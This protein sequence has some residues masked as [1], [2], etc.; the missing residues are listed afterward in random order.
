V[1]AGARRALVVGVGLGLVLRVAALWAAPR[2]GYLPD[3][4]D[5]M[6]WSSW[7]ATHGATTIY[8]MEPEVVPLH[9]V[10]IDPNTNLPANYL[11]FAPHAFNYPPFSAW[12]F[13]V[14]GVLWHALD[15]DARTIPVP[16]AL[17]VA[18]ERHGL[19][20]TVRFPRVNTYLTRTIDALPSFVFDVLLGLGVVQLVRALRGVGGTP[21]FALVF[22]SPVV[23]LDGAL[24]GQ[25]D[26]WI[27]SMLVWCLV[28]WLRGRWI[29][30]GAMYGLAVVTKPQAILFAPVLAFGLLAL[31]YRRGGS[32]KEVV[33]GLRAI[34]A[35]ALVVVAVAA[36]FMAHDAKG[37][38]GAWRWFE[39]SYLG[40]IGSDEYAYTTLNAFNLW[41]L[42]LIAA[43]PSDETWWRLL[44]SRA[45]SL[46]GLSK[47]ATG[48]VLLVVAIAAAALACARRLRW[49]DMACV[50]FA[51]VVLL[52]AFLLPTRAHERYVYYCVP[53]LTALAVARRPWRPMFLAMSLVGTAEMLSHLFVSATAVSFAASG[54]AA[55]IAVSMLP[56]S[57]GVIAQDA[58]AKNE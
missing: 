34:P 55:L 35:A 58:T 2:F 1:T 16:P 21:A 10:A 33:A 39:R 24:W 52:S 8:D 18:F 32:W 56:L 57:Y 17:R 23:I 46:I 25:S 11:V 41:W 45:P 53:F 27:A 19:A 43:R 47:D 29:A 14:K 31:W 49:S 22:A 5:S 44:D 50:T 40:T 36:P 28:W 7:A 38:T 12:V 6:A 9:R 48:V 13:W 37:G 42:D 3:H 54:A 30:A 4:L 20:M 26:S 15:S 51:F